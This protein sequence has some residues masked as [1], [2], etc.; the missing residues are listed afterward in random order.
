MRPLT[1]GASGKKMLPFM[2]KQVD[3]LL[4]RGGILAPNP[5]KGILQSA[6][7][8]YSTLMHR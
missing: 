4:Y 1:P 3:D 7:N 5:R 2:A 8:G 6:S